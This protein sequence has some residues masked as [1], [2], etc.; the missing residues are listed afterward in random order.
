MMTNELTQKACREVLAR[1]RVVRLGR[2]LDN[3]PYVVPVY[4]AY[5]ADYMYMFA[6]LGQKIEWMRLNPKVCMQVDEIANAAGWVSVIANGRY[7]ELAEPGFVEERAHA[8]K[9]LER[10]HGWWLN[11]LAERHMKA[12]DDLA[13]APIF[14][15]IHIDS[16]TG[17]S[18][19][20]ETLGNRPPV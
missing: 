3:Q 11:A 14:F 19:T 1:S 2:S 7:Q 4:F 5:E 18:A 6:T 15:R 10:H 17:L 16:M 13:I 20:T 12:P 8:Y 9:L